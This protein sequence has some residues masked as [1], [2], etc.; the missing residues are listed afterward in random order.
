MQ[1]RLIGSHMRTARSAIALVG[2]W[3]NVKRVEAG[4]PLLVI[5]LKATETECVKE[6]V[7]HG[8]RYGRETCASSAEQDGALLKRTE[9]RLLL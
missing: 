7:I 8:S 2:K 1:T 4:H 5:R 3:V 6:E 9:L